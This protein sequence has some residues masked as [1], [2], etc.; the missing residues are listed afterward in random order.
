M[1]LRYWGEVSCELAALV[2]EDDAVVTSEDQ[3]V[4]VPLV[5][6]GV[7]SAQATYQVVQ[8]PLHG[9]LLL[10]G[11]AARYTPTSDFHG[12]DQFSWRVVDG[13]RESNL[14]TFKIEVTS[15]ND[16]PSLT[17]H[18]PAQDAVVSVGGTISLVGSASDIE[19]GDISSALQWTSDISG[20]LG[21]GASVLTTLPEGTHVISATV[22]DSEG[23]SASEN[24]SLTVS[25]ATTPPDAT[26]PPDPSDVAPEIT[27]EQRND[28]F[29]MT[30][31]L[32]NG[33]NPVQVG[34]DEDVFDPERVAVLRG[35]VSA[36]DGQALSGVTVSIKGQPEF[37]TTLT[38]IDGEFDMV[39]NGG[40]NL[41]VE[42]ARAGYLPVQRRVSV[43]WNDF[44]VADDV[45]MI[46]L[47]PIVSTIDLSASTAI[48][49]AQGSVQS[50]SDGER[51]TTILFPVGT[52]ATMTLP[53]GSVQSLSILNVRATEYTVGENGPA[54]MPG[55]L[56]SNSAYTYAVELSVDEAIAAGATRVDFSSPVPVYVDNFLGFPVGTA[57]P[58]GYYDRE[59]GAWIASQNGRVIR[60]LSIN[61]GLSELDVEGGGA[62]ADAAALAAL[63]ITD[64]ERAELAELFAAG[65]SIWRVPVT[66]FT[67]WDFNWPYGLPEDAVPPMQP[68]PLEASLEDPDL[69]CGS[70]I[71]CQ[72]QILGESISLTGT[73]FSLHYRSNRM[74]GYKASRSLRVPLSGAELPPSLKGINVQISVAGRQF[75]EHFVPSPNLYHEFVWDGLDVYGRMLHGHNR[76]I[77]RI[78]YVY[79]AVYSTPQEFM[80]SFGAAGGAPITA[81]QSRMEITVWQAR[82]VLLGTQTV[83]GSRLGGW[84][85]SHHH[86]YDVST[87]RLS[88]GDGGSRSRQAFGRILSTRANHYSTGIAIAPD[89]SVYLT[90]DHTVQRMSS[91]GVTTTVAGVVNGPVNGSFGGDGGPATQAY[92]RYP[93]AIALGPDGSLYISDTQNQRI[94]RVDPQGV[95]STFAGSGALSCAYGGDNGFA[96]LARLCYPGSIAVDRDGSVFFADGG[97]HRIRKVTPDGIISTV[98]GDGTPGYDGDGGAA[99]LASL[100]HPSGIAVSDDGALYIADTANHV[101]RKV[102]VDGII[103]TF[104]GNGV[105][106]FAGDGMLAEQ[107]SFNRPAGV[108]IAPDNSVL[109]A[110]TSNNRIRQIN[111]GGIINT[112][113]GDGNWGS[114]GIGGLGVHAELSDVYSL[115]AHPDGDIYIADVSNGRILNLGSEPLALSTGELA[116]VSEDGREYYLFSESGR[117]L[118]TH[119]SATHALRYRFH[120]DSFSL[121]SQIEDGH[122]NT[123]FIERYGDGE[124][125]ALITPNGQ[126][127]NLTLDADGYLATV[128]N[129]ADEAYRMLYTEDGLLTHFADSRDNASTFTYDEQGRLLTDQNAVGGGWILDRSE[130]PNS[131]ETSLTS[132]EGRTTF[133]QMEYLS[134]GEKVRTNLHPDGTGTQTHI[135][136]D[137]ARTQTFAD[138]TVIAGVYGPDP[139]FGMDTPVMQNQS[140]VTPSGLT[141]TITRTR[142]AT[143]ADDADLL[144]HEA[145]SESTT[146][147]GKTFT[148]NYDA[149]TRTWTNT[150]AEGRTK[151]LTLNSL[152]Q[153]AEINV[154]GLATTSF[155][156]DSQGRLSTASAEY[157]ATS[158]LTQW[159]YYSSGSQKGF[160]QSMTDAEN[161]STY[162]SYDAAGRVTLQTLPDSRQ[163]QY[164]YD[165]NGN[166]SSLTPPGSSTHFFNYNGVDLETGY[167]PPAVGGVSTPATIYS[168]NLD[169][170][171]ELVTRP[172]G[173]TVD[174]IYGATSGQLEQMVIPRGSYRYDYDATSGQLSQISAPDNGTLAYTYDGSLPLGQRWTGNVAGTVSQTFNN[175][176]QVSQQCINGGLCVNFGYDRDFLLTQAGNLTVNRNPQ[177][178]GLITGTGIGG[179]NISQSYNAFGELDLVSTSSGVYG[180]DYQRDKLG[181][182]TQ[183]VETVQ[184]DSTTYDYHYDLAGRLDAVTENG[185]TTTYGYDAN[186]NRT[187]HDGVQVAAYDAQDR[188]MLYGDHTYLYTDNGELLSKTHTVSTEATQY[189]YDVLGNLIAVAL[190]DSTVIDYVIDGQN[191]RIG[192]KVNGTLVQGFLYQDQLNP[193]AELN[194]AGQVVSRFVYATKANVPDYMI[195]GGATYRI[196][197]NHLGSPRLVINTAT[198]TLAQR[199]DY[200]EWGQ[201]THDSN[202]GFQPFGFAGGIYDAHTQL[203]RFGARDYDAETGR[204][205]SKDPIRFGG[206]L[207]LYGYVLNNPVNWIDPFGLEVLICNR[208]VNGFP[209]VGNHAYAWDT[210][211]NSAE[212]MR[213]SSGSDVDSNEKGPSKENKQGDQC[214]TVKDSEGKEK[215]I[216]SFLQENQNKGMWF[217][218]IND[219]HNAV[220]DAVESAGLEYPGAPGGRFGD[221]Q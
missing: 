164:S 102:G 111:S 68:A 91:D 183:Q 87:G 93:F 146:I 5:V 171:L 79:D 19:E 143:L 180:A 170:Q 186:S 150:S 114:A 50:D 27:S 193:V 61:D 77:V 54:A 217:P 46:P 92:L 84:S 219:C 221:T 81:A 181:R 126:R 163:I 205:T 65:R 116:A 53:D 155:D 51:Q 74:S 59:R 88:R 125:V 69:E 174:F 203:T 159:D 108:A 118:S 129:P 67:P 136:T 206:G 110:D 149:A 48:Q 100:Y 39:V 56:P 9:S 44:T 95:I 131:H 128:T 200:N 198:G 98:A 117:H 209:F 80:Q 121:L 43:P 78:G 42:F 60:I 94:R 96:T 8:A 73:P 3:S 2:A 82:S 165:A 55:E 141:N 16:A 139:R 107:A 26:L 52:S 17:I 189:T 122:G 66:H 1:E 177:Q 182:I 148:R 97:N 63:G 115:A 162:F 175:D 123:T 83:T 166:L 124:P 113:A 58:S 71:E 64:S 130:L 199:L 188:L 90:V 154:S 112:I 197:S 169:K 32:F 30:D 21:Q 7:P 38:R 33:S 156:Y 45:V 76:A 145:L 196:L 75:E 184:G 120:Y 24:L 31:F 216:M 218:F 41:L 167:T 105:R 168:Y 176:F 133:Y 10:E 23:A 35:T 147:N 11:A 194:A 202:P 151:T 109:V 215:D 142:T 158:R 12:T 62:V 72:N 207:N 13:S 22:V 179:L 34:V 25:G 37:G 132:A 49:V 103:S 144:S 204:W 191:R 213:G 36:R 173:Q 187:H 211:T 152:G 178:G 18:A 195:K 138:G 134:S 47:D 172:D 119:D 214:K 220:Q 210:T 160:L 14:A 89:G 86:A 140:I 161:R 153:L 85:L 192:K 28:F 29:A 4:S 104:A 6:S 208:E 185:V 190:P 201:I 101:I 106:G 70:L 57:V 127:T 157:G 15:L 99:T 137:G 40:G 212:G 20:S 135:A